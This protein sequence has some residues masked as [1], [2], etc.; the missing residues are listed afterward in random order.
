MWRREKRKEGGRE[1]EKKGKE[2]EEIRDFAETRLKIKNRRT[3]ANLAFLRFFA[4]FF[5]FFFFPLSRPSSSFC[6]CP[7]AAA[8]FRGSLAE[9]RVPLPLIGAEE[10]CGK[11][12]I[13]RR[14][15]P[16]E[17]RRKFQPSRVLSLASEINA[18]QTCRHRRCRQSPGQETRRRRQR[19]RRLRQRRRPIAN[20]SE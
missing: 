10:S 6:G 5:S 9:S 2:E 12:C 7:R 19:Q 16:G 17:R 11:S 15:Q 4:S 8:E 3:D 1:G 20:L 13:R 18:N 14:R